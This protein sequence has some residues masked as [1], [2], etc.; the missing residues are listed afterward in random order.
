MKNVLTLL[1]IGLVATGAQAGSLGEIFPGTYSG[2]LKQ[3]KSPDGHFTAILTHKERH[4]LGLPPEPPKTTARWVRL[5]L[6]KERKVV[7]DSGY[8]PL[9]IYQMSPELA[10]DLIWSPDSSRIAYRYITKLRVIDAEGKVTNHDP[11][12]A[13]SSITCFR[14]I[15][16]RNLAVVA[17]KGG[18]SNSGGGATYFEGYIEEAS[19]IWIGK[20]DPEKG[21][22]KLHQQAVKGPTFLFH[23]ID[24]EVE[25]ISPKGDKVAFS[26]GSN[27]CVFDLISK[28]MAAKFAVPQ[29]IDRGPDPATL[30]GDNEDIRKFVKETAA[31]PGE[32]E[33]LWWLDNDRVLM[34]VDL[35][36][37][38]IYSFHSYDCATKDLSDRTKLLRPVWDRSYKNPNW[39]RSTVK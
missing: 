18:I 13:D 15:D 28:R 2:E 27:F 22:E 10:L 1:M 38:Y 35:L 21:Y 5:Q 29:E 20:L 12:E 37:N 34:G 36:G 17:K 33:G 31:K 32:I 26:D 25:E 9:N 8:E 19:D 14:W 11:P 39:F 30:A 7:Y 4:G 23:A 24:F 16:N 6:V 3:L